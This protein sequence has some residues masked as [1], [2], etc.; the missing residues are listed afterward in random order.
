MPITYWVEKG[1]NAN[2]AISCRTPPTSASR[3][4]ISNHVSSI[5]TNYSHSC[6]HYR[7]GLLMTLKTLR[8]YR[9]NFTF[10]FT[11]CRPFSIRFDRR[12]RRP[13]NRTR[14]WWRVSRRRVRKSKVSWGRLETDFY[15]L[16]FNR[17]RNI[18]DVL[19]NSCFQCVCETQNEWL[20]LDYFRRSILAKFRHF[21]CSQVTREEP[22]EV[23][24]RYFWLCYGRGGT[25]V[26]RTKRTIDAGFDYL[27]F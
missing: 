1:R 21:P 18:S 2:P 22:E 19:W 24:F 10:I 5:S 14:I 15:R 16:S 17:K 3:F 9:S 27:R 4:F 13:S 25:V 7:G 8:S 12:S 20:R 26:Y 23:C 6:V 11:T